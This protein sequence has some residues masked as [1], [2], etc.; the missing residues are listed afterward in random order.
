VLDVC[1]ALGIGSILCEGGARLAASLLGERRVHRLYL[2]VAPFTLGAGAVR[3]FPPDADA[4]SWRDFLPPHPPVLH[5]RD[6][7]LI[8]DR[9][10]AP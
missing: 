6:T 5:G 8:L 1:R 3:A 7:L 4:F 10:E 9:E 2:F